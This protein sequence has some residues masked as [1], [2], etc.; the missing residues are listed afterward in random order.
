MEHVLS[1]Q[2]RILLSKILPNGC[3]L[4]LRRVRRDLNMVLS[5]SEEELKKWNIRD[6]PDGALVW[7]KFKIT[8]DEEGQRR[9]VL[10]KDERGKMVPVELEQTAEVEIG[11]KAMDMIVEALKLGDKRQSFDDDGFISLCERFME[12]EPTAAG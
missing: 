1:V 7:D 10:E 5:F 2:D 4:A 3:S 12:K 6:L 11:E 8:E 9:P